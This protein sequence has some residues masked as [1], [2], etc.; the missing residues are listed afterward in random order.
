[1]SYY[2]DENDLILI[3]KAIRAHVRRLEPEMEKA[4][5]AGDK[6][7][8]SGIKYRISMYKKIG[9]KFKNDLRRRGNFIHIVED[10]FDV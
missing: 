4:R 7:K 5:V 1:M 2:L 10:E 9:V 6:W 8:S 3:I